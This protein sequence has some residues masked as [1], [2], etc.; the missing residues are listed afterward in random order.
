M[1]ADLSSVAASIRSLPYPYC[2]ADNDDFR[3]IWALA[4]DSAARKLD[5]L[6]QSD[7]ILLPMDQCAAS[8]IARLKEELAAARRGHEVLAEQLRHEQAEPGNAS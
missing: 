5:A 6:T 2:L 4:C 8:E 7:S 3:R 1:Q